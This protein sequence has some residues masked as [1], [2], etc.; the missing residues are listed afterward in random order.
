M[1]FH[2]ERCRETSRFQSRSLGIGGCA[3]EVGSST[4]AMPGWREMVRAVDQQ[5]AQRNRAPIAVSRSSQPL[6]SNSH[7]DR[8]SVV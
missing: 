2:H 1:L 5:I 3:P 7:Q 4:T 6:R 8:K